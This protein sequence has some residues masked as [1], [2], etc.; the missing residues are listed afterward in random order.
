MF[1]RVCFTVGLV[2]DPFSTVSCDRLQ[3][4][5]LERDSEMAQRSNVQEGRTALVRGNG[6][7]DSWSQ[8]YVGETVRPGAEAYVAR[9][10]DGS[11]P[12]AP[13]EWDTDETLEAYIVGDGM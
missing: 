5:R 7:G 4:R 12:Y 10:V 2:H 11:D 8:D 6:N 3:M 1:E 9:G 13:P